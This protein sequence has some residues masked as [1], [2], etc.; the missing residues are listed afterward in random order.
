MGCPLCQKNHRAF[1]RKC[2]Y[3]VHGDHTHGVIAKLASLGSSQQV[4]YAKAL[5][6]RMDEM[7]E[8]VKSQGWAENIKGSAE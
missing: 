3:E 4:E 5:A 1:P 7:E 2:Y 6:S 8:Y